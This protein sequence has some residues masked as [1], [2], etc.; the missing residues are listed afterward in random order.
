MG[1]KRRTFLQFLAGGAVGTLATPVVWQG[2]DDTAIW[3]QNFPWIPRIPKG[4]VEYT[5]VVSKFCSSFSGAKI[6]MIH[7]NPVCVSPDIDNPFS[8]GGVSS[9]AG[10]E[11]QMLYSPSRIRQ[12]MIKTESGFQPISWSEGI[13]IASKKIKEAGNSLAVLSGDDTS[14]VNE[15]LCALIAN[16]GSGNYFYMPNERQVAQVA[17][18]MLGGTDIVVY[19]YEKSN[20]IVAI[21]A[22]VVDSF[23]LPVRFVK[24]REKYESKLV[25]IGSHATNTYGVADARYMVFP[26]TEVIFMFGVILALL[27]KGYSLPQVEGI[28]VLKATLQRYSLNKIL[29]ETKCTQERFDMFI[30]S[31]LQA[32]SP[33]FLAGSS[34]GSGTPVILVMLSMLVTQMLAKEGSYPI[35]TVPYPSAI[36]PQAIRFTTQIKNDALSYIQALSKEAPLQCMITY[37]ANPL[38]ALPNTKKVEAQWN[39]TIA[40][41]IA[42]ASFMDETVSASDIVFPLTLSIEGIDDAYTPYGSDKLYY[43]QTTPCIEPVCDAK[44]GADIT[45]L[46]ANACGIDMGVH[47]AKEFFDKKLAQYTSGQSNV[48]A[49]VYSVEPSTPPLCSRFSP[50]PLQVYLNAIPVTP[51]SVDGARD[52]MYLIP[53]TQQYMGT[54]TTSVPPF[55]VKNIPHT[56][57]K[58]KDMYVLINKNTAGKTLCTGDKV[59]ITNGEDS[60]QARVYIH[61][62][63]IDNGVALLAG[64]GH[65]AF[66]AFTKNKGVNPMRVLSVE[67]VK[68]SLLCSWS[69]N[70]IKITKV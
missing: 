19:Q 11:V 8:L 60:I 58:D 31:I 13:E 38:Y 67:N 51:R 10:T 65:T 43:L 39:T 57:F 6:G 15:L 3:T 62:S 26:G 21:G 41:K 61:E 50:L 17:W 56:V 44:T 9:F 66:D 45:L 16:Q 12:P 54:P 23:G 24:L 49:K 5:P 32:H 48:S 2:I 37:Q 4:D 47:S 34:V 33:L 40:Y 30:N 52:E 63:V 64:L 59:N 69:R 27:D 14:S 22:N 68:E 53:Y 29:E 55:N 70:T 36:T 20:M 46:L 25:Y 28:D 7:G 18:E 42:L 1:V 35:G